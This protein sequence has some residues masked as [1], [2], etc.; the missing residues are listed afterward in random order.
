M[1][2][3]GETEPTHRRLPLQWEV[4]YPAQTRGNPSDFKSGL[5]FIEG[6]ALVPLAQHRAEFHA[7]E[8]R[9][10]TTVVAATEGQVR[11]VTPGQVEHQGLGVLLVDVARCE[12]DHHLGASG[13]RAASKFGLDLGDSRGPHDWRL[14]TQKL[15]DDVVDLARIIMDHLLRLRVSGQMIEDR[16]QGDRDRVQTCCQQQEQDAKDL[17]VCELSAVIDLCSHEIRDEIVSGRVT[18]GLDLL[19]ES[20]IDLLDGLGLEFEPRFAAAGNDFRSDHDV[21]PVHQ[22]L[23]LLAGQPQQRQE[24]Q[25]WQGNGKLLAEVNLARVDERVDELIDVGCHLRLQRG[26]LLRGEQGSRIRRYMECSGGSTPSGITGS[27]LP[28]ISCALLKISVLRSTSSMS[29]R[30]STAMLSQCCS[31]S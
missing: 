15:L 3:P 11:L 10:Q 6:N 9:A 12:G 28:M 17:A 26:H 20:C 27:A 5:Q 2:E 19:R 1:P 24:G 14:P 16:L 22:L 18:T 4:V 23:E 25:A 31:R 7:R 29:A 21:L 8:M 30:S 13:D